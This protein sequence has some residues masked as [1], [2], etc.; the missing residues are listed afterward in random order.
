MFES[1]RQALREEYAV[2]RRDMIF[3]SFHQ[4]V[5]YPLRVLQSISTL[6]ASLMAD[7]RPW[8][9]YRSRQVDRC[10]ITNGSYRPPIYNSEQSIDSCMYGLCYQYNYY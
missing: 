7:S 4:T 8:Q 1:V 2:D 9:V 5:S 3:T 6:S 10:S